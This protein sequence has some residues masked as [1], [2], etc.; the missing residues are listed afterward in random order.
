LVC[1]ERYTGFKYR[2]FKQQGGSGW[3]GF[4]VQG[5]QRFREDRGSTEFEWMRGSEKEIQKE[6]TTGWE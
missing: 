5:E 2:R 6:E 1:V 3:N 4:G